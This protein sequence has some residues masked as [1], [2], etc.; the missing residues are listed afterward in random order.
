MREIRFKGFHECKDGDT[1]IIV[2]GKE[3]QGKWVYGAFINVPDFVRKIRTYSPY[4]IEFDVDEDT[5]GIFT[6]A[7]DKDGKEIYEGN[8]VEFTVF[9]DPPVR[10]KDVVLFSNG[11]F[12][13]K[14]SGELLYSKT[15]PCFELKVVGDMWSNPELL[16][17]SLKNNL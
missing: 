8:I 13:L 4:G 12:C 2:N 3:R 10:V 17:R 5:V 16:T 7:C 9:S 14:K 11:C 1:T 15:V 6:G